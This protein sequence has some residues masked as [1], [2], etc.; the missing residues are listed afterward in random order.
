MIKVKQNLMNAAIALLLVIVATACTHNDGDIGPWF[1]L[2]RVERLTV[3][4]KND[5]DYTGNLFFAFQNTT[6]EQKM[7]HEDHTVTKMFGEWSESGNVLTITFPDARYWPIDGY[8]LGNGEP[9]SLAVEHVDGKH[10]NL[11]LITPKGKTVV[12]RLV[13]CV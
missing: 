10:I 6:V 5:R 1:G 11:T 13:K 7:V 2:W 3:D 8:L 12:Y 9:N 4:G